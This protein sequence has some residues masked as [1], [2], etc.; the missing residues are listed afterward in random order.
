MND[1]KGKKREDYVSF[2]KT[3]SKKAVEENEEGKSQGE[4]VAEEETT[5][6]ESPHKVVE[7]PDHFVLYYLAMAA[8]V[9]HK[10]ATKEVLP[11]AVDNVSDR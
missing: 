11:I 8:K 5:K 1:M 9:N 6:E 10:S 2:Y 7:V 4:G 3:I